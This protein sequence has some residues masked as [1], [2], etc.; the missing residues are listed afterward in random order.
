[1]SN[2]FA[3]ILGKYWSCFAKSSEIASTLLLSTTY[4]VLFSSTLCLGDD[5]YITFVCWLWLS[6]SC[7]YE[8]ISLNSSITFIYSWICSFRWGISLLGST[9]NLIF[10][11]ASRIWLDCSANPSLNFNIWSFSSLKAA[12]WLLRF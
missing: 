3:S 6:S 9:Y 1:M 7:S 5:S 2:C 8:F 4:C 10:F 11:Y 12:I